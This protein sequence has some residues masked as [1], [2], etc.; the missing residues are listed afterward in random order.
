[1]IPE[2]LTA[3]FVGFALLAGFLFLN[4][5]VVFNT[6]RYMAAAPSM[7]WR[8]TEYVRNFPNLLKCFYDAGYAT[9]WPSRPTAFSA[10]RFRRKAAAILKGAFPHS[11]RL[12]QQHMSLW[13]FVQLHRDE[14]QQAIR[15]RQIQRARLILAEALEANIR[16]RLVAFVN[17]CNDANAL[18]ARKSPPPASTA[19]NA[20]W[21]DRLRAFDILL[22]EHGYQISDEFSTLDHW[23]VAD[24]AAILNEL[25]VGSPEVIHLTSHA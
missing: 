6:A 20:G 16:G 21:L 11:K 23:A 14:L 4:S 1:M 17:Q 5:I 2:V 24:D 15:N 13:A 18:A 25:S 8:D 22:R 19:D 3:S 7:L 10:Y 9:P 12:V